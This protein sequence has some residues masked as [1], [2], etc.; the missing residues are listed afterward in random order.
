MSK[1]LTPLR[2]IRQHCLACAGRP[3][4]VRECVST[5][6]VLYSYRMGHNPARRGIAPGRPILSSILPNSRRVFERFPELIKARKC[7]AMPKEGSLDQ[8]VSGGEIR[9][10][11]MDTVGKVHMLNKKIIIELTQVE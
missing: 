11:R 4:Y 6:C 1:P 5:Q 10:I 7:L 9:L 8:V 2:A 3:K